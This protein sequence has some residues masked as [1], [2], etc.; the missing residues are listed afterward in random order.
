MEIDHIFICIEDPEKLAKILTEFGL[1]EGEPNSHIGQGTANRRFFFQNFCLELLFLQQVG[2]ALSPL[3]ART[4]LHAR[5]TDK[6]L[7]VSPFGICFRP[8]PNNIKVEN[9]STW[10]YFPLNIPKTFIIDIFDAPISEPLYEYMDFLTPSSRQIH[11]QRR[12]SLGV[13][14][15][16]SATI[17][18]PFAKLDSELKQD[19]EK[20]EIIKF[21]TNET[22]ILELEFDH[23][24]Q[25]QRQDFRPE[26][27]L[28]IKW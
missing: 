10:Q 3:T 1:T 6:S 15:L 27:P 9:Y 26:L 21:K 19:L 13:K 22:H 24:R 20:L 25:G 23:Q 16:T 12:H 11:V 18:T 8:S 28:I 14:N 7:D 2:R 17:H 5:L 4:T